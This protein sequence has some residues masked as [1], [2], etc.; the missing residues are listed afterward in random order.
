MQAVILPQ[1]RIDIQFAA[2]ETPPEAVLID[3][4]PPVDVIVSALIRELN[5]PTS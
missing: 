5:L 1:S 4:D 2:L 3:I